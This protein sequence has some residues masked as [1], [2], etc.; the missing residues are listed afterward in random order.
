VAALPH[1]LQPWIYRYGVA[2]PFYNV[3]RVVR[4]IIFNTKN[5]LGRN[6]GIL[7]V[8]IVV[9]VITIS[10]TT[11]LYRRKEIGEYTKTLK[12][13]EASTGVIDKA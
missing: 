5:E 4:T 7:L 9:S 2:M 8:W 3:S 11:Y 13:E 1:E 12:D 10:I 6:I